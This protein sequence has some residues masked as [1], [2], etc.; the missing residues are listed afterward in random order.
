MFEKKNILAVITL[1][2]DED[3]AHPSQFLLGVFSNEELA[4]G[5]MID[6]LANENEKKG[7]NL[8]EVKISDYFEA[9]KLNNRP[10]LFLKRIFKGTINNSSKLIYFCS[11]VPF[12]INTQ[13]FIMN[14]GLLF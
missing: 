3:E 8:E 7:L 13:T 9:S 2:R 5:N 10:N 6:W 1:V 11:I 12:E 14:S 4:I